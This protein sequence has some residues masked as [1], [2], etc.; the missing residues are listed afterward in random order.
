MVKWQNCARPRKLDG[1]GIKVIGKFNRALRLRWLW[2]AWDQ[3]DRPWK[4]ILKCQD[5]TERQLFF[6]ST[7]MTVGDGRKTPF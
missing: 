3:N 4:G 6:V 1:L 7:E 5:A 2:F